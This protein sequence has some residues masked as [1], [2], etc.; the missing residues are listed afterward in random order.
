M[1]EPNVPHP[2]SPMDELAA[3]QR[4]LAERPTPGAE[5]VAA[6]RASLERAGVVP[7][8]G[9][10][11]VHLN[12]D[13]PGPA[14]GIRAGR[15]R[16]RRWRRWQAWLA[17]VAAAAAVVRV[18]AVSL[19][20]SST[21]G[22]HARPARPAG[23]TLPAGVPR[24]FVALTGGRDPLGGKEAVIAATATGA[25]VAQVSP[26]KPYAEFTEVA[27]AGDDRSFVLAAQ[28]QV[29]PVNSESSPL[30]FFR[31]VLR[32]SGNPALTALPL[33]PVIGNVTGFALSPDGSK[34]AMA[35]SP[36]LRLQNGRPP[37]P[38][39]SRLR[40][41]TLATG[42]ERDW[43]LPGTGWIGMNK[44]NPQSLSWA[45]DNRRLLVHVQLG[46]GGPKAE[47]RVLDTGTPGGSLLAASNLVPFHESRNG[48][49]LFQVM[50]LSADGTKI[51]TATT[52]YIWHGGLTG[53]ERAALQPPPQCRRRGREA[54][55]DIRQGVNQMTPYCQEAIKSAQR[56]MI[57]DMKRN[58][59]TMRTYGTY[60]EYSVRTGKAVAVLGRLQGQGQ[61][62][63]DVDCA[64]PAGTTLIV[65]GPAPDSTDRNP[66]IVLGVLA[67][68]AFTPLPK[69]VQAL[70]YTAAW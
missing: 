51:I 32:R 70:I 25:T 63:A 38:H 24:Y 50:F 36:P 16:S 55:L 69:A 7:L 39:G 46:I 8:H 1:T 62:G 4:L 67:G 3:V 40:L 20:I 6:A 66:R 14:A 37:P 26:P 43:A 5:V 49:P 29:S 19:A 41:F 45:G 59:L 12:S 35:T 53:A 9:L 22:Q 48:G 27:A 58:P 30:K 31:L 65:D 28:R 33:P 13:R 18:V 34:L 52:R 54:R 68:N 47:V 61:T 60:G 23:V 10:A 21:V 2:D 57:Q 17:P 44:P 11:P 56:R 42:A 64:S 15:R